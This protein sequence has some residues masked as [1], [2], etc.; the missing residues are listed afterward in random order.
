MTLISIVVAL[1]LAQA[2]AGPPAAPPSESPVAAAVDGGVA[3][4]APVAAPP[5]A[6]ALVP[7]A[8]APAPFVRVLLKDG[9]SLNGRMLERLANGG[10][11]LEL[12]NQ[13][14][15]DLPPEAVERID[16]DT[17]SYRTGGGETW[18]LDPNRTRYLFGPSAMPLKKDEVYFSQIELAAS[19]VNWGVTDWL[20]V[21]VG[22]AVPFWFFPPLPSGF[23]LL[24][25][26]K[27]AAPITSHV[28]LAA[29]VLML[30]LPGVSPLPPRGVPMAGLGFGSVTYGDRDKHVTLSVGLP[31]ILANP[32]MLAEFFKAPIFT[33][34]G[35]YRLSRSLALV[36]ENWLYMPIPQPE[37]YGLVNSL[38]LRI[39]GD[40][41][42]TDVGFV[43]VSESHGMLIPIPAPWLNFTYNFF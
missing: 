37:S 33:L 35:N 30:W 38:A 3:A 19:T 15:L 25:G 36:T 31:L 6:A 1:T 2:E 28:H 34:S 21:Q 4:P 22:A 23:N 9:Q 43:I 11:V 12:G 29:G 18:S 5:S 14:R 8:P 13:V 20:A 41:L 16:L 40:K 24:L 42:A 17:R 26:G 32:T 10:L 27:V 7:D 39:M